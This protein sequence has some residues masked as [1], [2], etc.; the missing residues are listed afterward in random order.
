MLNRRRIVL[1]A[2]LVVA[3]MLARA[4]S[5][6]IEQA[7]KQG[8]AEKKE[9]L[10]AV[11]PVGVAE[12]EVVV[13]HTHA[14]ENYAPS[15]PHAEGTAGDIVEVGAAMVAS[16]EELGVR[17]VHVREVHDY[18]VFSQA[19]GKALQTLS[20]TLEQYPD[21]RAVI[22]AH[23][24]GLPQ[25]TSRQTT[26]V[27]IGGKDVARVLLVVGSGRKQGI[28]TNWKEN[29]GFAKQL[30][31]AMEATY[32]GLLRR[33]TLSEESLNHH[34]HG[35]A[36][37]VVIGDHANTTEEAVRG[38]KLFAEVLATVLKSEEQ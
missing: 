27:Q 37:F 5:Q 16:L 35:R 32:P 6:R 29:L 15:R 33:V 1:L 26:T 14:T 20:G 25:G 4:V 22:D 13:Y 12:P 36:L 21:V 17:A 2:S 3:L 11:E 30:A 23:R 28:E 9:T 34:L 38:A 7:T 19:Y 24:D 31:T 10:P 8:S 18:P